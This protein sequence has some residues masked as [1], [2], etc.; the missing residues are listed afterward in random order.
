[1]TWVVHIDT[2]EYITVNPLLIEAEKHAIPKYKGILA[3]PK[4]PSAGSMLEF[5]LNMYKKIRKSRSVSKACILMPMVQFGS[6][7]ISPNF[8]LPFTGKPMS[9]LPHIWD[10]NSF[11]TLRW[12]R[13]GGYAKRVGGSINPK[14]MV[15]VAKISNNHPIFESHKANCPHVPLLKSKF[16]EE[17]CK[18]VSYK[19]FSIGEY[20]TSDISKK[21]LAE[22]LYQPLIIHHYLGSLE[23]YLSRKDARRSIN[24]YNEKASQFD[25]FQDDGWIMGWFSDFLAVHGEE[26]VSRVLNTH[27]FEMKKA[28]TL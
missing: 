10:R 26:K 6:R 1:M 5:W 15:N 23:R 18:I 13:H 28:V 2:D 22:L 11:E 19:P 12:N 16:P 20:S 24:V 21:V 27:I 25:A 8:T 3:Y 9:S 4:T 17:D 7:E 14:S